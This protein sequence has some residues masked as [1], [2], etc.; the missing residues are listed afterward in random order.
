MENLLEWAKG[1]A[2]EHPG[3]RNQIWE[4]LTLCQDEIEQGGSE[5]HEI[6]LC[7]EDILQLIEG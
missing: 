3:H 6:D 7:K 1:I 4:L 5:T 2:K